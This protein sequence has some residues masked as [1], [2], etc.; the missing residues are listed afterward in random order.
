MC[1]T[2]LFCKYDDFCQE[3][4]DEWNKLLLSANVNS[5]NRQGNLSLSERMTIIT[6]FKL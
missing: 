1:C 2:A 4:E 6:L 5:R 3:F